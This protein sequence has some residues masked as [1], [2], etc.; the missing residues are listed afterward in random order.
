MRITVAINNNKT[1]VRS[2]YNNEP[3]KKINNYDWKMENRRKIVEK[4][5]NPFQ[6]VKTNSF[7]PSSVKKNSTKYLNHETQKFIVNYNWV[8][9]KKFHRTIAYKTHLFLT[10]KCFKNFIKYPNNETQNFTIDSSLI[11]I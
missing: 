2:V 7:S 4:S 6:P 5:V 9:K 1:E 10:L 3:I 11:Y 8:S